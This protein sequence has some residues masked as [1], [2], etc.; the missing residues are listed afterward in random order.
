MSIKTTLKAMKKDQKL[1]ICAP[2]YEVEI[3]GIVR[4]FISKGGH[5]T[6]IYSDGLAIN[7]KLPNTLLEGETLSFRQIHSFL[8]GDDDEDTGIFAGVMTR[9]LSQDEQ[10]ALDSIFPERD[11]P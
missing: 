6:A 5:I 7:R 11:E 3:T 10:D 4:A 8:N 9:D 1:V 2:M